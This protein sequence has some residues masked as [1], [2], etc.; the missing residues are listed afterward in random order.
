MLSG[1]E[2]VVLTRV[3]E[4]ADEMVEFLQTLVRIPTVNPPGE[5]YA[6]CAEVIGAKLKD[7]GY[8]VEYIAAEGLAECTRQHPRVNV[9]GRMKGLRPKPALH[10][11][12]HI[13][14]VP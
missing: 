8:E 2:N 1:S 7:F 12:G 3:D 4:L 11:N 5:N 6:D 10:F 14:V 9:I 13:D